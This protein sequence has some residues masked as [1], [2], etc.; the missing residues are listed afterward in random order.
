MKILVLIFFLTRTNS[1]GSDFQNVI[2]K[3]SIKSLMGFSFCSEKE[4]KI[5]ATKMIKQS[6]MQ[7]DVGV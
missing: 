3:H 7:N 5:G 6:N 2:N 1:H 4:K